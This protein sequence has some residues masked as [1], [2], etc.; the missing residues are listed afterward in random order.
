MFRDSA[1]NAYF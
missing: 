1:I